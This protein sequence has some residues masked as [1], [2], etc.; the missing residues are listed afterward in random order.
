M[1]REL[2]I[3]FMG[4]PE[5]AVTTLHTIIENGFNVV[6]VITAPDKPAGRGRKL[7]ASA[8]KT[9]ALSKGLTILQPTNL[10]DDNFLAQLKI[11]D[12]NLQIVVAFRMLPKVVWQ[13]PEYGTFNLHA[14]LLPNYRGAAP[15][16]WAIINGET[17]SGV[18]TFF[19]DDKIDTG[20]MILQKSVK[21]SET[22]T[23][24][25]LHDVLMH[26]GGNL[27][28][29]TLNLIKKDNVT[30]T[31]Q[32]EDSDIKTAYKLNKDNCYINWNR[33]IKDIYNQVRGLNPYPAAWCLLQNG[34]EELNVK[35]YSVEAMEFKHNDAIGSIIITKD[36]LKVAAK[37]GYIE[38]TEI[39]LPG[40]RKM[41][42]KSLL[43]GFN[44]Q[45]EAKM[46]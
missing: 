23:A 12:A 38:L 32:I 41:D 44:F 4:T 46:L 45:S 16:N 13:M 39:K 18:S 27:V 2:R 29:D 25:E 8:V 15:I 1:M 5:F 3:V 7:N 14:S 43:N 31:P 36:K 6:G 33:S 30:T 42:V 21:I 17:T 35:V 20:E 19:I 10:K 24:G 22:Q 34:K 26:I 11:L 37:N 9:Y 40:K 28:V